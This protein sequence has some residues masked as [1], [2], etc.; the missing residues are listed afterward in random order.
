[1]PQVPNNIEEILNSLRDRDEQRRRAL[2]ISFRQLCNAQDDA[3]RQAVLNNIGQMLSGQ[4]EF[5]QQFPEVF[6]PDYEEGGDS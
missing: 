3:E 6:P 4:R 1:M 5:R 2:D